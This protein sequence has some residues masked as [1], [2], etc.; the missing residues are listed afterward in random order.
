MQSGA[1]FLEGKAALACIPLQGKC[2]RGDVN[3]AGALVH[4]ERCASMAG[5]ISLR[6]GA[7]APEPLRQA[8]GRARRARRRGRAFVKRRCVPERSLVALR[9]RFAW[10]AGWSLL[11]GWPGVSH[12]LVAWAA[13]RSASFCGMRS[14]RKSGMS[15]CESV[16][17]CFSSA[18]RS[19]SAASR[20]S[21]TVSFRSETLP[22]Q[23][24]SAKASAIVSMRRA[25]A[26]SRACAKWRRDQ[27]EA[28]SSPG[29]SS[30]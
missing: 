22:S 14:R 24:L 20:S 28:I 13:L 17:A 26:P 10:V 23:S 27:T 15:S 5:A 3:S 7:D 30:S 9:S 18:R 12:G 2:S 29:P 8:M 4:A 6:A 19:S 16:G 1:A 11:G 21:S 25:T